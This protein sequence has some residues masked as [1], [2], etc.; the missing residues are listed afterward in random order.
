MALE[1]VLSLL[2]EGVTAAGGKAP[3]LP[4]SSRLTAL[5]E[6]LSGTEFW[7]KLGVLSSGNVGLLWVRFSL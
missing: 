5:G 6:L 4:A 7:R 2:V 1:A 3:P